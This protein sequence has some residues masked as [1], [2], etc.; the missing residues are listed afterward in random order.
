V[1]VREAR[2]L[3][4]KLETRLS[5]LERLIVDA[6]SGLDPDD[7]IGSLKAHF[8]DGEVRWIVDV[9]NEANDIRRQLA[10]LRR[11]H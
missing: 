7:T 4:R 8:S 5:E 1:N 2:A 11:D 3:Y 9:I 10:D 6:V